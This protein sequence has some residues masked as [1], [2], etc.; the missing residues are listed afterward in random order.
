MNIVVKVDIISSSNESL[1]VKD[2]KDGKDSFIIVFCA[3]SYLIK[4]KIKV[5]VWGTDS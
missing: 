3:I 5:S 2:V 1:Y 4:L